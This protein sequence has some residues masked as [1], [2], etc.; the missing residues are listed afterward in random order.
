VWGCGLIWG[1]LYFGWGFDGYGE[2]LRLNLGKILFLV[3]MGLDRVV[4]F[5]FSGVCECEFYE[6]IMLIIDCSDMGVG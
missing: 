1:D 3:E 2:Y 5:G 4:C 6:C